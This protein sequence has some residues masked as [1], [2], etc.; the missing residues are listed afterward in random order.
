M[1]KRLVTGSY[2]S[3]QITVPDW[4][5]ATPVANGWWRLA[6]D[7]EYPNDAPPSLPH[8]PAPGPRMDGLAFVIG[9]LPSG[10]RRLTLE[11]LSR[12]EKLDPF[13]IAFISLLLQDLQ[14]HLGPLRIDGH[15]SHPILRMAQRDGA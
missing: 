14:E 6:W 5:V 11:V 15:H 1:T 10:T 12:Y 2:D 9:L 4:P 3:Q 8:L 7:I 13:E